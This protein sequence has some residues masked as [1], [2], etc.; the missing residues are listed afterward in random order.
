MREELVLGRR[1]QAHAVA[2]VRETRPPRRV[3]ASLAV[4]ARV[5]GARAYVGEQH[6]DE[7]RAPAK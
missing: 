3:R 4:A 6:G 2:S 7:R 5:E 1:E